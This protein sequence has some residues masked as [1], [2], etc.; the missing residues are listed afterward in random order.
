MRPNEGANALLLALAQRIAVG[1]LCCL[2]QSHVPAGSVSAPDQE[3]VQEA[4][5]RGCESA[6]WCRFKVVAGEPGDALVRVRPRGVAYPVEQID[7][8]IGVRD[9][10]NALLSDMIHQAKRIE[11][12]G[13]RRLADGTSSAMITV[14]GIDV[15]D[16][17]EIQALG[18]KAEHRRR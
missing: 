8:A 13:L 10:L 17:A 7:H 15:S 18:R 12:H 11:L 3:Q 2:I 6:G 5:F 16:D 14:H 9:R 1:T 4:Q